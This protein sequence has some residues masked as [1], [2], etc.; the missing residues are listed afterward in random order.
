[1]AATP[2]AS[3]DPNRKQRLLGV[4]LCLFVERIYFGVGE[5]L[6]DDVSAERAVFYILRPVILEQIEASFLPIGERRAAVKNR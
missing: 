2:T 4:P 3:V 1:M 5:L 6:P